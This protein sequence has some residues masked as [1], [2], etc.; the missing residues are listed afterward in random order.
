MRNFTTVINVL[1]KVSD[2]TKHK[3]GLGTF[4]LEMSGSTCV[5]TILL[6]FVVFLQNGLWRALQQWCGRELSGGI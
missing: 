5:I 4:L 6:L 2:S 3:G 1:L